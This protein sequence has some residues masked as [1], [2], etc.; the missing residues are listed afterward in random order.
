[1]ADL[2]AAELVKALL[3]FDPWSTNDGECDPNPSDAFT[4]GARAVKE[5][6]ERLL[7]G[8]QENG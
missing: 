1:M 8:V 7:K 5:E 3:E 4:E 2:S 6:A